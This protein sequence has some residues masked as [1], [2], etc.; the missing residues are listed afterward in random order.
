MLDGLAMRVEAEC[1]ALC[2]FRGSRKMMKHEAGC[3]G[4]GREAVRVEAECA[5]LC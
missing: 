3:I 1:T 4:S 2:G 5:A